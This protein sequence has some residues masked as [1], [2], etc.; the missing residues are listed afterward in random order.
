MF[1]KKD[2]PKHLLRSLKKFLNYWY[3]DL[4][5]WDG[6]SPDK[7]EQTRLPFPLRELYSFAGNLPGD[8]FWDSA[9]SNQ[10]CL[11]IYEMLETQN[12][13]LVFAWENQGGWTCGTEEE[14]EDPPVWVSIDDQPW[15][16]LCDSL[17]QFLV[18]ICLHET[19][20]NCEYIATE[21]NILDCLKERQKYIKP[22]WLNGYY[23]DS[24]CILGHHSFYLADSQVLI[25]DNQWCGTNSE[26]EFQIL[27][28]LFEENTEFE[29]NLYIPDTIRKIKLDILASQH[30]EKAQYH[31][32]RAKAYRKISSEIRE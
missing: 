27:L 25:M 26:E 24:D 13:K 28:K 14:G 6:I 17:S 1:D 7:L 23:V 11:V 5:D 29:R 10:D 4:R 3:G 19:L 8:N 18:T 9:F 22:L 31:S 21:N 20:F 15:Q 30:E 2:D 12:D 32:N 16:L